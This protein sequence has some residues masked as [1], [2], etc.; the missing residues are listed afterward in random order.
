M[1]FISDNNCVINYIKNPKTNIHSIVG[2]KNSAS[3]EVNVLFI[4]FCEKKYFIDSTDVYKLLI[5]KRKFKIFFGLK[6]LT[7]L[8]IY[9]LSIRFY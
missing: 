5:F 9:S 8:E 7:S 4:R 3:L 1:T 2:L 6:N